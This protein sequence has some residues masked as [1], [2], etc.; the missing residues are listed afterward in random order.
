M[1]INPNK[2]MIINNKWNYNS[3]QTGN[4]F[5]KMRFTKFFKN[6]IPNGKIMISNN[7]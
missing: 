4:C 7:K 5:L 2:K 3:S 1:E 6:S